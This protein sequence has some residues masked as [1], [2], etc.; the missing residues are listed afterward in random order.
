MCI[1]RSQVTVC[2]CHCDGSIYA[3]G[4][5]GRRSVAR[6]GV[7]RYDV[8]T[9]K[10]TKV[11]KMHERR[12]SACCCSRAEDGCIYVV[13]G[14]DESN[15]GA[16]ASCER[17]DPRSGQW[18]QIATMGQKRCGAALAVLEDGNLYVVGGTNEKMAQLATCEWYPFFDYFIPRN[19]IIAFF[20]VIIRK[21]TVGNRCQ[22]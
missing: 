20:L 17:F 18:T 11:A 12:W 4:G 6:R 16:L 5:E 19:L 21:P 9:N 1:S 15:G 13:G 2:Q 10:W 3:I 22:L 7:E 14:Y 8:H